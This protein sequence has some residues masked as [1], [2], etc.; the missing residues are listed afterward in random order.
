MAKPNFSPP[1]LEGAAARAQDEVAKCLDWLI[2][3]T[4]EAA[5]VENVALAFGANTVAHRLGRRPR[6]LR[7]PSQTADA[8]IWFDRTTS[9]TNAQTVIVNASAACT[10]DL[11]FA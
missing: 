1:A 3:A 7:V 6:V 8:R 2:A 10:A 11:E 9:T 5:T 4:D